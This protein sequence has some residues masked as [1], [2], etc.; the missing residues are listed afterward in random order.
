MQG[1][2]PSLAEWYRIA[3]VGL[4][5]TPAY[6]TAGRVRLDGNAWHYEDFTGRVGNSDVSGPVR[7]EPR[8]SRPFISGTLMSQRLDLA[9]FGPV[10]GKTAPTSAS[11]PPPKASGVRPKAPPATGRPRSTLLPQGSFSA[12]KW[13]TLDADIQFEGRSIRNLGR[14]PFE[15]VKMHAVMDNRRLTL[16][17]LQFGF[18]GGEVSTASSAS[19]GAASRWRRGSTSAGAA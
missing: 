11:T 4:P 3:N 7:F 15:R 1:E 14:S 19:T 10:I 18:A 5:N 17:P 6:R 16:D 2:G 8:P 9:D 12:Q 13:D